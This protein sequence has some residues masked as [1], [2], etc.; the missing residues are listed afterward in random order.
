M[1]N[2]KIPVVLAFALCFGFAIGYIAGSMIWR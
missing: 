1:D 2:E